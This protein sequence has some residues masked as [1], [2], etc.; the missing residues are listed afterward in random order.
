MVMAAVREDPRLP[1]EVKSLPARLLVHL[2]ALETRPETLQYGGQDANCDALLGAHRSGWLAA[3]PE[4]EEESRIAEE[5]MQHWERYVSVFRATHGCAPVM[6][7]LFCG[8]GTMGRGAILA[9]AEVVGLTLLDALLPTGLK[10]CLVLG[11][12]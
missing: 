7:D 2:N 6:Y 9:G 8:E 12:I 10:R 1:D 5:E 3:T 11:G 4:S